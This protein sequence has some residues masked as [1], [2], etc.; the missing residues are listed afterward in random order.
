MKDLGLGYNNSPGGFRF[1][2]PKD[3]K[4]GLFEPNNNDNKTSLFEPNNNNEPSEF[5]WNPD[6]GNDKANNLFPTD[7]ADSK[8]SFNAPSD[9]SAFSFNPP[10]TNSKS[11]FNKPPLPSNLITNDPLNSNNKRK[12]T[13]VITGVCAKKNKLIGTPM[14]RDMFFN[15][16]QPSPASALVGLNLNGRS[17]SGEMLPKLQSCLD[18]CRNVLSES[19]FILGCG[20]GG[21]GATGLGEDEDLF[22]M[23]VPH[24]LLVAE[25]KWKQISCGELNGCAV[26][27]DGSCWIW[28]ANDHGN[29]GVSKELAT[30]YEPEI[31]QFPI[32]GV[33]IVKCTMGGTHTVMCDTEGRLW[34][35]GTF[36][37]D[38]IVGHR[39]DAA[40]KKIIKEQVSFV[41]LT[42]VRRLCSSH[43]RDKFKTLPRI[44]DISSGTNHFIMLDEEKKIWEM[45]VT[46][47][48]QRCSRRNQLKYLVPRQS[49][50]VGPLASLKF[51]QIV[52]GDYFNCAISDKE[53]LY[54]W[55]QNNYMQC[56]HKN[57]KILDR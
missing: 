6:P 28:G 57:T 21:M 24:H 14:V 49:G 38:G 46:S 9:N 43:V 50:F 30:L 32:E 20:D 16:A 34:S 44:I 8:F 2:I 13:S 39:Y 4:P 48:G 37:K 7:N 41:Q 45:G 55:G 56:G 54:T 27:S 35:A 40:N 42:E 47:L 12:R 53:E 31:A 3:N 52:C 5:V 18:T 26:A 25:K 11:S 33:K 10:S 23:D 29:L 51:T 19:E 1:D 22:E 15:G 17:G 36:K